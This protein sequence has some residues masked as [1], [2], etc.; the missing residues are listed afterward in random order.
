MKLVIPRFTGWLGTKS[1]FL[2][3]S[4]GWM[5]F[6]FAVAAQQPIYISPAHVYT[7]PNVDATAFY[8][9]GIWY[10]YTS[11]YPFQTQNTLNY[12]NV[13]SMT[14]AVG[15]EFD[16]GPLPSGGRGWSS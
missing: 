1:L 13:G 14:G 11:P 3:L 6:P 2:S 15:W 4:F 12:T 16:F 5:L 9:A 8:N 10:I 7:P